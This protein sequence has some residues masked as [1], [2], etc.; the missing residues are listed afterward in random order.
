VATHI[1]KMP[2]SALAE[3]ARNSVIQSGFEMEIKRH[4]LGQHW[5]LPGAAGNDIH[6][7][8]LPDIRLKYRHQT[9]LDELNLVRGNSAGPE[10]GEAMALPTAERLLGNPSSA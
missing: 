2:Q 4:W 8:N 5:Y 6:K 7:T 9:L 1:Y 10:S 3:L